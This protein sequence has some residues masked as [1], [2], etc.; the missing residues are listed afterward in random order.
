MKHSLLLDQNVVRRSL[1]AADFS[2]VSND[3]LTILNY[4]RAIALGTDMLEIDCHLTRDGKVI[5]AHDHNLLRSTGKNCD[6][7][8]IDFSDLPLLKPELPMDFDPGGVIF[9]TVIL[10]RST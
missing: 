5:V 1:P 7:S 3:N 6:I 2:G 8:Q 9:I 4:F 10:S